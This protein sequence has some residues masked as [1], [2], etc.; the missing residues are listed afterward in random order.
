MVTEL[1]SGGDLF[2]YLESEGGQVKDIQARVITR[3]IALALKYLHSKE[4]AHRD[5][6]P[7]N[8]LI[9]KRDFGH[10]VVLT[11]FGLATLEKNGSVRM[12]STVGTQGYTAP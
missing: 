9:T 2:S 1:A 7:E 6:K 12:S 10:R 11:D 8:I 4:I 3:Q 5:V